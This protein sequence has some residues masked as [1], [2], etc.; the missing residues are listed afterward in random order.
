[1]LHK[2]FII[3]SKEIKIK[4][5]FATKSAIWTFFFGSITCHR[6]KI[7][8]DLIQGLCLHRGDALLLLLIFATLILKI[9][10]RNSIA[11]Y[12]HKGTTKFYWILEYSWCKKD[13]D[14][15]MLAGNFSKN[16]NNQLTHCKWYLRFMTVGHEAIMSEIIKSFEYVKKNFTYYLVTLKTIDS[17][18]EYLRSWSR[19]ECFKQKPNSFILFLIYLLNRWKYK[20]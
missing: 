20:I 1:M 13:I 19:A 11:V 9:F 17:C 10:W 8:N 14:V 15:Q 3:K 16:W 7:G 4:T 12:L 18:S 6:A 2:S 5:P